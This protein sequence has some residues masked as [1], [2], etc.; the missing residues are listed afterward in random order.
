MPRK[1]S[2]HAQQSYCK[3]THLGRNKIAEILRTTFQMH[4]IKGTSS[5]FVAK[6]RWVDCYIPWTIVLWLNFPICYFVISKYG[7]C[8]MFVVITLYATS[9]CIGQLFIEIW[10]QRVFR[11]WIIFS[12]SKSQSLKLSVNEAKCNYSMGHHGPK[13]IVFS[14][15]MQAKIDSIFCN[16]LDYVH[17]MIG[18]V[19]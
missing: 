15:V 7:S 11:Y 8:C 6:P 14:N 5:Y 12:W 2:A 18:D 17:Q 4:L 3:L 10:L 13:T 19:T 9:Y 16:H 1:Y